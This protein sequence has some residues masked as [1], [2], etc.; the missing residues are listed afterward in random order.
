[1][2]LTL[3]LTVS[4]RGRGVWLHKVEAARGTANQT[5]SLSNQAR[6]SAHLSSSSMGSEVLLARSWVEGRCMLKQ[7]SCKQGMKKR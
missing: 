5:P 1:M 6:R 3:A 4:E 7:P 2:V